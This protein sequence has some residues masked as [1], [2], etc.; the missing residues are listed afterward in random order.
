VQAGSMSRPV[1]HQDRPLIVELP[2]TPELE[3]YIADL[4]D[5][6]TAVRNGSVSPEIDNLLKITSEG[7]KAALDMRLLNH[8][9]P[10]WVDDQLRDDDPDDEQVELPEGD[11]VLGDLVHAYTDHPDSKAYRSAD[12]IAAIYHATPHSRAAQVVFSDLGTP[13]SR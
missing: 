7:R 5:R 13:K 8:L 3:G 6:A 10:A 1:L 2:S 11:D 9:M 4:A 12:L